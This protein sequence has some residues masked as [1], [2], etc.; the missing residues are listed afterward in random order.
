MTGRGPDTDCD[1]LVRSRQTH[2]KLVKLKPTS[3]GRE[4]CYKNKENAKAGLPHKTQALK[5]VKIEED[6]NNSK[7]PTRGTAKKLVR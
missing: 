6:A 2:T 1:K 4:K 3:K 5:N 7:K